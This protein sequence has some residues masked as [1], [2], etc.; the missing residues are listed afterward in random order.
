MVF[1]IDNYGSLKQAVEEFCAFLYAEKVPEE[2]VFHC[3]LVAYELVGNILKHAQTKA[4]FLGQI[5]GETVSIRVDSETSFTPPEKTVCAEVFS[6]HGRGLF[7]ID[8]YCFERM[9][10]EKGICVKI[11]IK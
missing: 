6:E 5:D 11:K 7:L 8:Q 9:N 3:K 4:R 2:R 1:E 10:T